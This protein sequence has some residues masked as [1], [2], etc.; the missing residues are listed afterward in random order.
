[1]KRMI[2][3]KL[4]DTTYVVEVERHGDRLIVRRGAESYTVDL[5]PE[6]EPVASG[7]SADAPAAGAT[8]A[9]S[10]QSIGEP[11]RTAEPAKAAGAAL[12]AA[13]ALHAPMTGVIKEIRVKVGSDV[14]KGD[15]VLVMEAM[16]MDVEVSCPVT[17]VVAE[18]PVKA[19]DTVES[20]QVLIIIQ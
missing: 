19:G 10:A 6:P 11:G 9:P 14:K 2:R 16:K 15:V 1:M 17:G 3:F 7:V 18:I 20:Q 8:A 13:G 12:P 4:E 5:L